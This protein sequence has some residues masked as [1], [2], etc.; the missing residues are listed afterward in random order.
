M[1]TPLRILVAALAGALALAARTAS[2]AT[3]AKTLELTV[4]GVPEGVT[5]TDFPLLVRLSTE[6]DGFSYA[7]FQSADG[8]DLRFE[9]ANGNGLAYDVDTWDTSGESLVW[10]KVPSLEKGGTITVRFGSAAPDANTPADV[11]SNYVVVYHG[12]DLTNSVAPGSY[13][14]V[15]LPTTG[16]FDVSSG[17]AAF[18]GK[19]FYNSNTAVG[20]R[21][22]LGTTANNP[23]AA[24]TSMS[25]VAF[26]AW[27][28]S[29]S[30]SPSV[31]L[32][33]NK[34]AY[35]DNGHEFLAVSGSGMYLRGNG[36]TTQV[37]PNTA[38]YQ[39]LKNQSWTFVAATFDGAAGT[40]YVNDQFVSGTVSTPTT[41][42]SQG[43]AFGGYSADNNKYNAL[44]GYADEIR[45]YN[46][47]PSAAYLAAEYA[48]ATTS[49]YV[50]YGAVQATAT[51]TPDF[52]GDAIVAR[53][54]GGAYTIAA[55]VTGVAGATY[56]IAVQ[57]N[58]ATVWTQTW[59]ASAG[60]ETNAV[61]WTTGS[62][63]ADG[64]YQAAVSATSQASGAS[65]RRT[66]ADVFLVGDVA[67]AKGADAYEQGLVAGSFVLTRPGDA[68]LPLAVE[69]AVSSATATAGVSYQAV[70]GIATF[71]AGESSVTVAIT[72]RNDP[73]LKADATL[74]LTVLAGSG[75]Y[76]G[77]GATASLTLV[78]FPIPDGYNAWIA[79]NDGN[80]SDG[81]NWSLGRAPM[82]EDNILLGAWSSRNLTWDAAATNEVASWTQTADFN[83]Q[84][85]FPITYEGAD[86]DQGFNL[87]TVAGDVT[88]LGGAWVHPVQ[89]DSSKSGTAPAQ[90]YRIAV[91]AGGD[92]TVGAGVNISALGRGR[93]YWTHEQRNPFGIHAGYGI[94]RTNDMFEAVSEPWFT[95]Y[96]SILEPTETGRG[97]STGT[98]TPAASGHGGGAIH[99]V[100]GGAFVNNGRVVADGQAPTGNTGGSGGSVYVRAASISGTGSFEADA[101]VATGSGQWSASSGGR[102]ALVA[103]GANSATAA[104]TSANGS[105]SP[106]WWQI[107]NQPY[108]EAAAG[109]V[110][111]QSGTTRELL[112]RNIVDGGLGPYVRAYTPLPGDDGAA[113]K[114]AFAAATLRASDNAR[115]RLLANLRFNV[116]EVQ[117]ASGSPAYVD[118]AG[119]TL[120]VRELRTAAGAMI[121]RSGTYTVAD[122]A[123]RGWTWLQ[124]S[125]EA[126]G[127]KLVV[128]TPGTVI[129]LQ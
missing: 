90:R 43:I 75:L 62:N 114:A 120:S 5:L 113:G 41:A 2:A 91:Q 124:D 61:S 129:L 19:A 111:L 50:T 74:A 35:G 97:S 118:L 108:W 109:T 81:A 11:W 98:D 23:L 96:G 42:G 49:G 73:A 127:G 84:V 119:K 128:G 110:W 25:R 44:A 92:F 54:A 31:R 16:G 48:Q 125:S 51:D 9:D 37:G 87:F 3:Y 95:P 17:Q 99:L 105:R 32:F 94:T 55:A 40:M 22:K 79:E 53:T 123:T 39:L 63:V 10:V 21:I 103:T 126:K 4:A 14:A 26:S 28:K 112:V 29:A 30:T 86:V 67:A 93:G 107:N 46:G 77:V 1:K 85:V 52:V 7:D 36:S 38:L 47:V 72:P 57:L 24:L 89:G 13:N 116:L 65:V 106:D 64:T 104:N 82:A 122:A 115:I 56:D 45:I 78:D 100:A 60:D 68:T 69:Y 80:A 101:T 102:V 6:I 18:L 58:G 88:L 15:P 76:G 66:V 117:T 70:S 121:V 12:N 59:T 8:T 33:S 83:A 34:V 27:I 71:G 20:T